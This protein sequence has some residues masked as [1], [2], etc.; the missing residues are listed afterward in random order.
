MNE[1]TPTWT[2]PVCNRRIE[3][4][5][6]LIVDEYFTEML[7]NTPKHIDSV[8][9]EPNG[10]ITIIV[11]NPDLI[12]QEG[13]EEEEE[14]E[15]IEPVKK[16]EHDTILLLDDDDGE[17]PVS[18]QTSIPTSE[19]NSLKRIHSDSMSEPIQPPQQKKKA[20]VIDLTLDSED[21]EDT[22]L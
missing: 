11:E 7:K 13:E 9:V 15:T 20:N 19:R 1:Q 12:E 2:C 6:D 18:S 3:S 10:N 14:E 4:W 5:E 8:R 17:E 16:E 22:P 21:E